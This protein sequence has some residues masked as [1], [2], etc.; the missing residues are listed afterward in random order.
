[1][2]SHVDGN[3]NE[4][5]TG[6]RAFFKAAAATAT[7]LGLA[8]AVPTESQALTLAGERTLHFGAISESTKVACAV[9]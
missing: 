1:M 6:R 3:N 2:H 9:T 8:G 4:L 7:I 5:A